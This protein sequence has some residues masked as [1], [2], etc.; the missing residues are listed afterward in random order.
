M[1]TNNI[2]IFDNFL[3]Q[4]ENNKIFYE[5]MAMQISWGYSPAKVYD[6]KKI[7]LILLFLT[8]FSWN[9]KIVYHEDIGSIPIYRKVLSISNS[10]FN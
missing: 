8:C 9:P 2:K 1:S 6:S 10:F 7:F 5:M 3:T 4:R